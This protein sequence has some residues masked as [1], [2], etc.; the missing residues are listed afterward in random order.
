MITH[1]NAWMNSIG[2]LHHTHDL[3]DRYLWT[4]PMF[5]ANGWT[6]V[7]TSNRGGRDACLSAQ[8]RAARGV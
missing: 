7:W 4:L 8:S 3:C 1:R 2:T 5:H 6:F